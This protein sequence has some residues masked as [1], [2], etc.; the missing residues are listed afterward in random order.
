MP[1]VKRDKKGNIIAV[2]TQ[3]DEHCNEEVDQHDMQLRTFLYNLAQQQSLMSETDFGFIRVVEDLIELLIEKNFIRFTDLPPEAQAKVR[4]RQSLR[5]NVTS[6][7][8]LLADDE[9]GII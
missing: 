1:F 7:L 8:D 9:D 2:A 4:I 3:Q 5:N 6:N